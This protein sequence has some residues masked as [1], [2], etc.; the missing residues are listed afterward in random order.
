[1]KKTF[2]FASTLTNSTSYDGEQLE[3]YI[4]KAFTKSK[5]VGESSST[6]YHT[7]HPV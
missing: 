6:E 4:L 7:G 2:N 5:F 3:S 1:M